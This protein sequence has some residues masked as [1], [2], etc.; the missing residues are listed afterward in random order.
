MTYFMQKNDLS[1]LYLFICFAETR[2]FHCIDQVS[3]ELYH[4][5][6]VGF[7]CPKAVITGVCPSAQLH[8]LLFFWGRGVETGFP[9]SYGA[10]PELAL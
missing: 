9:S 8:R 6:Q 7:S 2:S 4:T 3:L 10:S 1:K 5:A